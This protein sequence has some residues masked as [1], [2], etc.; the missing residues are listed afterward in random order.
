MK[1]WPSN[2]SLFFIS[3]FQ[4]SILL[5]QSSNFQFLSMQDSVKLQLWAAVNFFFLFFF[6]VFYFFI[7]Y[8]FRNW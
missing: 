1:N 2:F 3:I 4:L 5:I 8:K 6:F 7:F